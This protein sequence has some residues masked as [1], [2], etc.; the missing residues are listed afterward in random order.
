MKLG[1]EK[2]A[3]AELKKRSPSSASLVLGCQ[4][5]SQKNLTEGYYT[6]EEVTAGT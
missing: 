6:P 5:V 4:N 1:E 3:Q 2:I